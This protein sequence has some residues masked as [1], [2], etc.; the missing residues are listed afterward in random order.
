MR[1]FK[2][3]IRDYYFARFIYKLLCQ[4]IWE[5]KGR[6]I[7][8][9]ELVKHR[10]VKEYAKKFSLTTMVETGTYYGD[11]VNVTKRIFHKIFSIEL[12]E[13]FYQ[14]AKRRFAKFDH[15]RILHGDSSQV[16]PEIIKGA[17]EPYL[18]YLDAHYQHGSVKVKAL[19]TPIM[20]ELS[21]ILN[22][23]IEDHVILIDD[24]RL[25]VGK[26]DWPNLSDLEGLIFKRHPDWVFENKHDVIRIH[27]RLA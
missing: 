2:A 4:L 21:V 17:S 3:W 9:P 5:L 20:Q 23:N 13:D 10:I 1:A 18:F 24:A 11:T 26:G 8:S 25:F 16:L 27:R 19:E 22:H 15:I 7:P 12:D 6:P 14:K